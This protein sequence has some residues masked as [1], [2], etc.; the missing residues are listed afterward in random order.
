MFG[1][2]VARIL[3]LSDYVIY[4]KQEAKENSLLHK[5]HMQ[6]TLCFFWGFFTM[7]SSSDESSSEESSSSDES[8]S[9]ESSSVSSFDDSETSSSS[10]S[11]SLSFSSSSSSESSSSL[12]SSSL[13]SSL[14]K[15]SIGCSKLHYMICRMYVVKDAR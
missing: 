13:L 6:L 7:T 5:R 4:V 11:S 3:I 12:L 1:R 9:S 8:S 15:K 10:H 2:I 14:E